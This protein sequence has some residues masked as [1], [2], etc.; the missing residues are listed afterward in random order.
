MANQ[1][2][3]TLSDAANTKQIGVA[4]DLQEDPS[5]TG[6]APDAPI[7]NGALSAGISLRVDVPGPEGGGTAPQDPKNGTGIV[8]LPLQ[9]SPARSG[10]GGG[11]S[12]SSPGTA[13]EW[14]AKIACYDFH[15]IDM[16]CGGIRYTAFFGGYRIGHGICPS[17]GH[18][19]APGTIGPGN[20]S[21]SCASIYA[22]PGGPKCL[23]SSISGCGS[24][25]QP[26]TPSIPLKPQATAGGEGGSPIIDLP[27]N[28]TG[29]IQSKQ[30]GT[31]ASIEEQPGDKIRIIYPAGG[32]AP[33]AV[34]IN[35]SGGLTFHPS[36]S[37]NGI[38]AIKAIPKLA[39]LQKNPKYYPDVLKGG[40][41]QIATGISQ[42]GTSIQQPQTYFPSLADLEDDPC[43]CQ[44][45]VIDL[46]TNT[47][48]QREP[49]IFLVDKQDVFYP[50]NDPV[51]RPKPR[52]P[53]ST[54]SDPA[55]PSRTDSQLVDDKT[56]Q[57]VIVQDDASQSYIRLYKKV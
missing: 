55:T 26:T 45:T 14:V 54:K 30:I 6:Q 42:I 57:I 49:D 17:S 28:N 19:G 11:G 40:T 16:I 5:L 2:P 32:G 47:I 50:T 8:N 12:G 29:E 33:I 20:G 38:K 22:G 9:P 39:S 52:Q 4:A 27:I 48:F 25:G 44:P 31:D 13:S 7:S 43:H 36:T 37:A 46:M 53:S 3:S 1:T 56:T 21:P 18:L 51:P 35:S 15:Y 41:S 23:P 24:A 10:T 34:S